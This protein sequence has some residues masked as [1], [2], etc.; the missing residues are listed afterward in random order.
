MMDFEQLKSYID[1]GFTKVDI[2]LSVIYEL[3][4]TMHDDAV[5]VQKLQERVNQSRQLL[6]ELQYDEYLNS[7]EFSTRQKN[8]IKRELM[9]DYIRFATDTQLANLVDEDIKKL[10]DEKAEEKFGKDFMDILR[11]A[12]ERL[13]YVPLKCCAD[14]S[15]D[16]QFNI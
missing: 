4:S 13:R 15:N 9:E 2:A 10:E 5:A 1:K 11:K 16:E 3:V 7:A 14:M 6:R 12:A 8:K